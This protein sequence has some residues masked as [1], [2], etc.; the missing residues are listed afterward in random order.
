MIRRFRV[1]NYKA[2]R[3]VELE[4]TPIHVLI[5]PNDS[6][7]TSIL[8]AMAALCRSVDMDTTTAFA[9]KWT[10]RELIW[11]QRRVPVEFEVSA[12]DGVIPV[13]YELHVGFNSKERSATSGHERVSVGSAPIVERDGRNRRSMVFN[14]A[15]QDFEGEEREHDV[16]MRHVH[17]ALS[18]VNIYRWDAQFLSIPNAPEAGRRFKMDPSGFGLTLCLDQILSYDRKLFQALEDKFCELFPDIKTIRLLPETGFLGPIDN[19]NLTQIPQLRPAEGKGLYFQLANGERIPASQTSDGVLLV[20]AYLTILHLPEKPR[21]LLIEEP[22]NGIHPQRLQQ[23]IEILKD[24]IKDQF[25]TQLVLTTHSPYVVSLF[26]PQE[27]TLCTKDDEGA[28]QTRRLSDSKLVQEQLDVFTLGEIW[29]GD[30]DEKL[31][32]PAMAVDDDGES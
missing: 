17:N 11:Q 15:R 12:D 9:G 1:K 27:V 20:L 3:D 6:G 26:D 22:E 29:T 30:G 19:L 16:S 24:L 23:V 4:L 21:L 28:V 10:G 32:E 14:S 7:K 18:G 5:G 25:H 2:L 31:M 8:E 13:E